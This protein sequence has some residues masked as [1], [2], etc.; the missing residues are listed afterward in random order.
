MYITKSLCCP[1]EIN[2]TWEI[3]Y[4]SVKNIKNCKRFLNKNELLGKEKEILMKLGSICVEERR[5][6][7]I[8]LIIT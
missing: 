5:L 4:T 8:R 6:K 7:E 3:N 1:T 2:T